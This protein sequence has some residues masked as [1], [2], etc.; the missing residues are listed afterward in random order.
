VA[1]DKIHGMC[2]PIPGVISKFLAPLSY[3]L[4][5]AAFYRILLLLLFYP[6]DMGKE[7]KFFLPPDRHIHAFQHIWPILF[8]VRGLLMEATLS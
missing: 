6:L 4:H 5:R 3:S 1:L 8:Y 2:L 7:T